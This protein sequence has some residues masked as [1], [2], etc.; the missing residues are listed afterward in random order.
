M[1]NKK[2]IV[3]IISIL[4]IFV[5]GILTLI[6]ILN[7]NKNNAELPTNVEEE[8]VPEDEQ[9]EYYYDKIII[10]ETAKIKIMTISEC[11][12][13][14]TNN[15]YF[16]N[17][18]YTIRDSES[19]VYFSKGKQQNQDKYYIVYLDGYNHTYSVEETDQSTYDNMLQGNIDEKYKQEAT[20]EDIGDN[21]FITIILSDSNIANMYFDI[22]K[23][24][25]NSE[26]EVLYD[27]LDSEYQQKRFG[28]IESFME[29][30]ND[31]KNKFANIQ[32]SKY[33]KYTYDDY[34]QYVCLDTNDEY[35]IINEDTTTGDYKILLDTY[36]IDQPEFIEKYDSASDSIRYKKSR[37]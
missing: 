11:V 35:Y 22:I 19:T 6:I 36:T 10:K 13:A 28:N 31:N 2:I 24:L 18:A 3:I 16:V 23:N 34:I 33:A 17:E 30:V 8:E 29:Y 32:I 26:P 21:N 27:L 37:I 9:G 20:V 15:Y 4:I 1:K 7:K 14:K 5:I 12:S 25:L